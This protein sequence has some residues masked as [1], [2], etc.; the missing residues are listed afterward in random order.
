MSEQTINSEFYF[1]H[2]GKLTAELSRRAFDKFSNEFQSALK[3]EGDLPIVLDTNILLGYYGMS[4]LEKGKLLKFIEAYSRRIYITKQIEQEFLKNRLSVIKKDLFE[5]LGNIAT[6]YKTLRSNIA[7]LFKSYRDKRKKLLSQDYNSLWEQYQ[8][9][10]KMILEKLN[11]VE[12]LQ[13]IERQVGRTTKENINISLNDEML[14]VVSTLKQMDGLDGDEIL[15][16]ETEFAKLVAF[17]NGAK[18]STRW[19]YA[20]PGCG[21]RDGASGDFIIFHEMMK[22]MKKTSKSCIF[23]TNDFVKGDWF[24]FDTKP[25]LH[26]VEN[27]FVHTDNVIFIVHAERTLTNISFE[28]IH[29][30]TLEIVSAK[31]G[32]LATDK[33]IDVTDLLVSKIANNRLT[34]R[35]SNDLAGDPDPGVIKVLQIFYRIGQAQIQLAVITEGETV[36][37]PYE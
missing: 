21:D 10:E 13:S 11:D 22:F 26:Y 16:L 23:L 30:E 34:I 24:Q 19:R 9:I 8:L 17:Y 4:Q 5:P 33:L 15:F 6:D 3:L 20:F 25:H 32:T 36:T 35:A 27:T 28:N 14:N 31:Y 2:N 29:K 18:A 37:I 12:F 1:L 7:N